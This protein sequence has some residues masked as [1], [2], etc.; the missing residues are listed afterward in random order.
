MSTFELRKKFLA[1]ARTNVGKVETSRCSDRLTLLPPSRNKT[2]SSQCNQHRDDPSTKH[3]YNMPVA[4]KPI[5]PLS[6][7]DKLRFWSKVEVKGP[8]E[9]W[10][11]TG[12]KNGG[13]YGRM[14]LGNPL[15]GAHRIS[16]TIANGAVTEGLHVCHKCDNPGC[17]NPDHLFA[18]T[19]KENRNDCREKGRVARLFGDDNPSRTRPETLARGDKNGARLHPEK[20]ARGDRSGS[21]LHPERLMRGEANSLSKLTESQVLSARSRYAKG[22]SGSLIAREFGVSQSSI[23]RVILRKT[24]AHI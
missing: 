17:C 15:V 12:M 21:R 20:L 23:S 19:A 7:K 13:G 18:G 9:C 16:F 3:T 6:E 22:E 5:P 4:I 1:I 24:W 10:E 2:G 11:W 8:D 14:Y